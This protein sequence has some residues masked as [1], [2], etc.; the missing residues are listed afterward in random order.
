MK[1]QLNSIITI[2]KQNPKSVKELNSQAKEL[3]NLFKL[4]LAV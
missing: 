4:I 3:F 1:A 2:L